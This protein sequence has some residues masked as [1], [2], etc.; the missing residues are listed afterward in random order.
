MV[1]ESKVIAVRFPKALPDS[2]RSEGRNIPI[3]IRTAFF[4]LWIGMIMGLNSFVSAAVAPF[5]GSLTSKFSPK[6]LFQR[7]FLFN[8]I[9]FLLMGFSGS[10]PMLLGLRLIQ[11]APDFSAEHPA[12]CVEGF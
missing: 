3:S 6:S 1:R 9:I 7:A 12:L 10:L 2:N 11:G 4:R 5:W 8:G